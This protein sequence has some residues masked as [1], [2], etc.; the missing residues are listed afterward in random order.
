MTLCNDEIQRRE[1]AKDFLAAILS[2]STYVEKINDQAEK[3]GQFPQI[4]IS[5]LAIM[6]AE[7]FLAR[8][9]L[10]KHKNMASVTIENIDGSKTCPDCG[11][12][13]K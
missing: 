5:D 13:L 3:L 11:K 6:Q 7:V 12:N 2:N 1:C 4:L 8:L 9:K 10:C